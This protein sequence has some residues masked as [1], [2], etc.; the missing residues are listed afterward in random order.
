MSPHRL[1]HSRVAAAIILLGMAAVAV[2]CTWLAF[3][4][5]NQGNE[6]DEQQA[7]LAA[8]ARA[9][10]AIDRA[11]LT[12]LCE[13]QN[14]GYLVLRANARESIEQT[15]AFLQAGRMIPGVTERELREAI[16]RQ[17]EVIRGLKILDCETFAGT[18]PALGEITAGVTAPAVAG[19]RG[20][21]GPRGPAGPA[22]PRGP[23]GERGATG[24]QGPPGERGPRGRR[25]PPGPSGP[26]PCDKLPFC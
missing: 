16:S 9:R 2:L 5:I 18:L 6:L 8:E 24:P 25:G 13:R 14:R 4:A 3:T 21:R 26:N 23:R 11:I 15:R 17:R 7:D 12:K 22:G 1:F 19:P 20:P 10:E